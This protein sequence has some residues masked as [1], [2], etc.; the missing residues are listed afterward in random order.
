MYLHLYTAPNMNSKEMLRRGTVEVVILYDED[1]V[2]NITQ[3]PC[4]F[5]AACNL[6]LHSYRT[7]ERR[8]FLI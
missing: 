7:I 8:K 2:H 5:M 4:L 6:N 1:V 3:V